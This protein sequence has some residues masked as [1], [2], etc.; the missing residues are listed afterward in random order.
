VAVD[1]ALIPSPLPGDMTRFLAYPTQIPDAFASWHWHS[2]AFLAILCDKRDP[3]RCGA[4]PGGV[5]D[6]VIRPRTPSLRFASPLFPSVSQRR[7]GECARLSSIGA[8]ATSVG[9][10]EAE[11]G[12]MVEDRCGIAVAY[13]MLSP[14]LSVFVNII[15]QLRWTHRATRYQKLVPRTRGY[16][17]TYLCPSTC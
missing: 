2:A 15:S 14:L 8:E 16:G 7:F 1:L 17:E 3:N 4:V 13:S 5:C 12:T 9:E 6:I 10:S 11:D